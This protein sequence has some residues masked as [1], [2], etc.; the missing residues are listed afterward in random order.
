MG[1]DGQMLQ[2]EEHELGYRRDVHM[3]APGI[4]GLGEGVGEQRQSLLL[5]E[6]GRREKPDLQVGVLS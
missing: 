5:L 2:H 1:Q 4:M 3:G 6:S